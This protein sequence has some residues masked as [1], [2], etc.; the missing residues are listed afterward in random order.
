[1]KPNLNNISYVLKVSSNVSALG[2]TLAIITVRQFPPMESLSSLVSLEFLY[3]MYLA[4]SARALMQ[5]PRASS[6]LLMFDPSRNL[7]PLL[8][9]TAP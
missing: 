2:L 3:G 6:D 9:V 5:F 8:P 4:P 1:M 7:A